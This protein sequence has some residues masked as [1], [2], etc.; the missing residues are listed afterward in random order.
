MQT[1]NLLLDVAVM[2]VDDV[3]G[4]FAQS[5]MTE[6][7][8][9]PN[10]DWRASILQALEHFG[11]W[12]AGLGAS[13]SQGF[14]AATAESIPSFS[15]RRVAWGISVANWRTVWVAMTGMKASLK[16]LP[17]EV[18]GAIHPDDEVK[19]ESHVWP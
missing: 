14:A 3:C 7:G 5:G 2:S 15:K 16:K 17:L 8:G 13:F 12:N 4:Q 10:R 9:L 19:R 6:I 18:C 1:R 11:D